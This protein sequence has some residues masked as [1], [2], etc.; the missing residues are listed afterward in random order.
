MCFQSDWFNK[1]LCFNVF[2]INSIEKQE[3]AKYNIKNNISDAVVVF[4]AIKNQT[5]AKTNSKGNRRLIDTKRY[6]V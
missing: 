6:I 3:K 1:D 2:N 4:L 5:R